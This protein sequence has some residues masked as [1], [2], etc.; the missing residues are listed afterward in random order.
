MA[1]I[2]KSTEYSGG[3]ESAL[4]GFRAVLTLGFV[5]GLLCFY[6]AGLDTESRYGDWGDEF[7]IPWI[8]ASVLIIG[9]TWLISVLL[10]KGGV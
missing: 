7:S 8:V 5:L 2:V 1:V 3:T 4:E 10:E 6:V 9:Q